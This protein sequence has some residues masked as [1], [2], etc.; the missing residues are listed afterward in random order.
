M[1]VLL[2]SGSKTSPLFTI[3]KTLLETASDDITRLG[4]MKKKELAKIDGIGEG[5][6]L[7]LI[8]AMELGRRSVS[9][10]AP[11]CLKDDDS[12]EQLIRPYLADSRNAQYHL[13]M[14]NNRREL[15]AT[16]E[17]PTSRNQLPE[18]KTIMKLSLETGAAEII[19]CRND[20]RLPTKIDDQEKAFVIQLDAAAS[21]FKLKFR[22]LLIVRGRCLQAGL[23]VKSAPQDNTAIPNGGIDLLVGYSQSNG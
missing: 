8:A 21:I 14:L 16:S 6:A 18:L 22:G 4:K 2:G 23:S 5:K 13:V 20:I 15:L 1:A 17:L 19:L 10:A 12:I 7:T 11:L 9:S 3:C